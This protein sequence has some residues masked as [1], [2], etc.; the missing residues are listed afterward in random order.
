MKK[1]NLELIIKLQLF[2][3][4]NTLALKELVK[5]IQSIK[6]F[7]NELEK[8]TPGSVKEKI[9]ATA[10]TDFLNNVHVINRIEFLLDAW[11][12]TAAN[13]RSMFL[14]EDL[15]TNYLNSLT[16]EKIKLLAQLA[17]KDIP[18]KL[19]PLFEQAAETAINILS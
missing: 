5:K 7:I 3:D 6:A 4:R 10:F 2:L 1:E 8:T 18:G 16:V 14:I 11:D 12:K 9:V 15:I 17:P 13:S 19:K